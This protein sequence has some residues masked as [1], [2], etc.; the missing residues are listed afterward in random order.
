MIIENIAQVCH[1][2]NRA[3][4]QQLGDYSQSPW[5]D[6]DQWQRD[7]AIEG[8]HYHLSVKDSTPAHSHEAWMADKVKNGWVY[9][10]TKDLKLKTHPCIVLFNE[11][12]LEQ[13]L[14]DVLFANIVKSLKRLLQ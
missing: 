14:K 11:L 2:A 7:S 4:C 9:G 1:E 6:A 3:Y 12:P 5:D 10:K 8:V 13:Q